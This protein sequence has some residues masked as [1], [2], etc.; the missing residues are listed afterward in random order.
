MHDHRQDNGPAPARSLEQRM[1]ALREANRIRTA[2]A[3]LKKRLKRDGR[4]LIAALEL[5]TDALG[6]EPGDLDTM[7]VYDL[8]V[9]APKIGRV[10]ANRTL[11][12]NRISPSKTL[13]GLSDRQRGELVAWLTP[14]APRPASP[15]HTMTTAEE[16][17]AR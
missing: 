12:Y 15:F 14:R 6:L 3:E 5:N 13:G 10:K 2:R 17:P 8:L 7:K 1:T 9:A 4:L 11:T 16:A